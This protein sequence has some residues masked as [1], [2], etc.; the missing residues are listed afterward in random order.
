MSELQWPSEAERKAFVEKLVRFRSTLPPHEQ[1]MLDAMA[2]AAFGIPEQ[3]DE[4]QGFGC[5]PGSPGPASSAPTFYQAGWSWQWQA[6][7]WGHVYRAVPAAGWP[8]H[9][10]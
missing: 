4:V 5:S 7:P 10:S 1:R 6:T 3:P 8:P 2:I 9:S